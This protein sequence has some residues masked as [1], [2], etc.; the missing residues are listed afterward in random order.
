MAH[1]RE[2][3]PPDRWAEEEAYLEGI[4]LFNAL[5]FWESHEAW[6]EIWLCADGVHAE[7]LQGLIQAAAALLKY[8]R[9]EPAPAL[10]LYDSAMARLN[11]CQNKYMGLD[12][13]GFQECMRVCFEPVIGGPYRPIDETRIPKI[14]TS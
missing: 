9:D 10:R 8:Q 1:G 5:K 11:L 3:L 4:R 7:F 13:R 14:Q 12:V 2:P 6:E